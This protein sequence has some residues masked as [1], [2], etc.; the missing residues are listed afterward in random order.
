MKNS[1]RKSK[2]K[3]NDIK[4]IIVK[5]LNWSAQEDI[6]STVFDYP[7]VEA[8]TRVI[9]KVE[10][11]EG[12]K[13]SVVLE[14]Y[15]KGHEKDLVTCNMYFILVNAALYEKAENMRKNFKR[16]YGID[17]KLEEIR[18]GGES[19]GRTKRK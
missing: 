7:Y 11:R 15:E 3:N 9:K 12:F 8:A 10:N 2:K 14:C 6:D 19:D 4:S 18:S 16:E 1:K 17:L 5:G 13:F